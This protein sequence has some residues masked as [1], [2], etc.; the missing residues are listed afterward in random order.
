M[1]EE[2][3]FEIWGRRGFL[4][5]ALM[6]TERKEE[7]RWRPHLTPARVVGSCHGWAMTAAGNHKRT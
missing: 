6:F 2:L 7:T 5:A 4:L 3:G 1:T